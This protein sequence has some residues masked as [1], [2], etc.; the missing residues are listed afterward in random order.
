MRW[1]NNLNLGRLR[2]AAIIGGDAGL[3]IATEHVRGVADD[4]V[5]LE[6]GTLLR[7][8]EPSTEHPDVKVEHDAEGNTRTAIVYDTPYARYQHE[9]LNLRHE[10]GQAKYLEQPLRTEANT[11]RRIVGNSVRRAL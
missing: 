9:K 4:L 10:H 1:E 2:D 6:E 7:S 11:A 5:P 3:V 8:G